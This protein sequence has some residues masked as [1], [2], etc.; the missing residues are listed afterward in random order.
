MFSVKVQWDANLRSYLITDELPTHLLKEQC[1]RLIIHSFKFFM[2]GMVLFRQRQYL[3]PR[4]GLCPTESKTVLQFLHAGPCG[5]HLATPNTIQKIVDDGYSWPTLHKDT[6]TY[7]NSCDNCQKTGGLNT[8]SQAQLVTN[9]LIEPFMKWAID[10]VE[11]IKL[12]G[13]YTSSKYIMV[14]TN[15]ATKW[16]KAKAL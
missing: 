2:K 14:A 4:R 6:I 3:V 7:C 10:L 8:R 9:I 5:G 12:V 15:Y 13:H 1:C 16:V 11:P